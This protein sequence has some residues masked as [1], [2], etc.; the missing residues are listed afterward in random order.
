MKK[1]LIILSLAVLTLLSCSNEDDI[2]LQS[3]AG[4]PA[5]PHVFMGNAYVDG[6]PIKEGIVIYLS[7]IH[8]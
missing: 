7:L 2:L 5:F 1:I 3:S 6:Q 4:P 8:I